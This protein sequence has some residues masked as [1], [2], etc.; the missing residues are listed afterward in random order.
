MSK[1]DPMIYNFD[2]LKERV[3]NTL[4]LTNLNKQLKKI[5]GPTIC[6]GSGGSKVVADYTSVVLSTI[7]KCSTT[8]L[9]PRDV[10]Y[11]NY[12]NYKNIF[13]CS[14]SGSNH[15]VDILSNLKIKKQLLTYGNKNHHFKT[16]NCL[17]TIEKELSFIS[18][19]ATIMPM[20]ILLKY[21]LKENTQDLFL[22]INTNAQNMSYNIKN[23]NLPFDIIT[24]KDTS[25]AE[26]FLDSTFSESGLTEYAIHH[27]YDYCH[28]RSTL[29]F[30]KPRN[31]IYLVTKPKELDN[32]LLE[33][34]KD[35]YNDIIIL[36]SNYND[37]IIDNFN[38][39]LQAMY[40]CKYLAENKNIDLSIVN[41]DKEICKKLYKYKGEL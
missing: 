19:S 31:L 16:L 10:L 2:N 39:T 21:Y 33:I 27:K 38:L 35:R 28:G 14:Y 30:S 20:S 13:V 6:A 12:T 23:I 40:L 37:L 5:K 41:Y 25:T 29:A 1:N 3:L 4:T 34:L 7:N 18:L 8:V 24:G 22:Q 17:S 11:S 15:G 9:E 36:Q 26:V 32:L